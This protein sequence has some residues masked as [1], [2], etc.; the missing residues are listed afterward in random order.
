MLKLEEKIGHLP[1]ALRSANPHWV[2]GRYWIDDREPLIPSHEIAEVQFRNGLKKV[3]Y[4]GGVY[5]VVI[6]VANAVMTKEGIN[7]LVHPENLSTDDVV[8]Y[9]KR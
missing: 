9:K 3:L 5:G 8:S 6:P 2:D 1:K 4:V 7:Y